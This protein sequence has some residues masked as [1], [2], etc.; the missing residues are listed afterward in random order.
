MK[1]SFTTCLPVSGHL[2][3][4]CMPITHPHLLS[5]QYMVHC[6]TLMN[7]QIWLYSPQGLWASIQSL[8]AHASMCVPVIEDSLSATGRQI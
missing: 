1:S 5:T 8:A 6:S 3:T 7:I 2:D 4:A